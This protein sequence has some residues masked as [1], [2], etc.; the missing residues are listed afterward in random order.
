M[1]FDDGKFIEAF[2]IN[3]KKDS[4]EAIF[5]HTS[6]ERENAIIEVDLNNE[7]Y[8]KLLESITIDDITAFTAEKFEREQ[9]NFIEF[10]GAMCKDRGLVYDPNGAD[11]RS[12]LMLADL[13]NPPEGDAGVDLLFNVKMKC[14]ELPE[15]VAS[16]DTELKKKLRKAT[17]PLEAF[18]ITGQFLYK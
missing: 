10:V 4:V 15:V 7:V 6:G 13:F 9:K 5:Q 12:K 18:Y 17:T 11:D 2:F 8:K 1:R 14:F 16:E 3:N